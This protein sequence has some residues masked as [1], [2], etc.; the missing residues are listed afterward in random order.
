VAPNRIKVVIE[1]CDGVACAR[2]TFD[3]CGG[4]DENYKWAVAELLKLSDELILLRKEDLP[5]KGSEGRWVR[6]PLPPVVAYG[7]L[8]LGDPKEWKAGIG[9]GVL[10]VTDLVM[11]EY[12]RDFYREQF[13]KVPDD[14]QDL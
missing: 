12:E 7:Q 3:Q 10:K 8:N 4:D 14:E 6:L 13:A 9:Q 2:R 1:M 11:P 5:Y